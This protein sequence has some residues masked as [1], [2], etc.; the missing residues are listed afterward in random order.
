[1]VSFLSFDEVTMSGSAS[2]TGSMQLFP[3]IQEDE[4]ISGGHEVLL[5]LTLEGDPW[6][7][8]SPSKCGF[9]GVIVVCW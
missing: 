7:A 5:P 2:G 1:M 8:S 3:A 6:E 9:P 4:Q